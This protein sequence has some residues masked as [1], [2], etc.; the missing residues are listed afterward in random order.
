MQF[1]GKKEKDLE[2]CPSN[3]WRGRISIQIAIIWRGG[4][5]KNRD[6]DVNISFQFNYCDYNDME[7][8]VLNVTVLK[9]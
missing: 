6:D 5:A 1:S 4:C 3:Q 9:A 2:L 7:C 8:N